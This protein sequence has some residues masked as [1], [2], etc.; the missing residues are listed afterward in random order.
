MPNSF[1]LKTTSRRGSTLRHQ[2][3]HYFMDC[4][5]G[6]ELFQD[7]DKTSSCRLKASRRTTSSGKEANSCIEQLGNEHFR[8][9]LIARFV[10]WSSSG[11][12]GAPWCWNVGSEAWNFEFED[13]VPVVN[14]PKKSKRGEYLRRFE[15]L[16]VNSRF[17]NFSFLPPTLGSGGP[18]MAR[19]SVWTHVT[20]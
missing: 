6:G 5:Q 18:Q 11:K 1:E 14:L 4:I 16:V 10:N 9:G 13:Q 8:N 15:T 3:L 20:M 17:L 7:A 12:G 2:I 19:S